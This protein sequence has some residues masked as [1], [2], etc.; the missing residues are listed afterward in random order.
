MIHEFRTYDVKARTA[1]TF[2]ER[3][4]SKIEKR[5]EYSPLVGLFYTEIGQ[6]NRVLHIW[7]YED[8]NER[9]AIRSKVVEDGVWPPANSD[10]ITNMQSDIYIPAPFMPEVDIKRKIGPIFELRVYRYPGGTIPRVM[11][12]WAELIEA[13]MSLC[14]AVG[15]WYSELGHLNMWA[16]MWAY[17]SFEH[18]TEARAKFPDIGWPPKAGIDPITQENM[19]LLAAGCSPVQ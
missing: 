12:A 19:I 3:F 9:D 7:Q 10:L 17:E 5:T 4:G 18:R 13:R 11:D 15:V 6:L 14:P 8:L 2:I 1:P 16:H